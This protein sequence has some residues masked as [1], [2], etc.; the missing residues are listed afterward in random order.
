MKKAM[1]DHI[2]NAEVVTL[3]NK[4]QQ[5]V[6]EASGLDQHVILEN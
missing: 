2:T 1:E 4:A 5:H 3:L 6:I